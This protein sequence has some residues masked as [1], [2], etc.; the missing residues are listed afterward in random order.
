[1][2]AQERETIVREL[3]NAISEAV[4]ALQPILPDEATKRDIVRQDEDEKDDD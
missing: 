4:D 1:L 2:V 3:R